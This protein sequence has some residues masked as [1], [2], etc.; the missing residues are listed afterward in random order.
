MVS[1]NTFDGLSNKLCIQNRTED[2][3]LSVFNMIAWINE[4]KI[5]TNYIPC[6]SKVELW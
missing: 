3:N 5:L 6:D 1:C 2:L 4:S